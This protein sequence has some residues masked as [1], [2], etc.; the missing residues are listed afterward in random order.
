VTEIEEIKMPHDGHH[1]HDHNHAGP[2]HMHSHPINTGSGVVAHDDAVQDFIDSFIAG[3]RTADDKTGFL[4]LAKV[5][6]EIADDAGGPSLKLVDVAIED[7]YQVATASPAFA[8]EELVYHP[9]PGRMV[10]QRTDMKFVY[11]S[12]KGRRDIPLSEMAGRL[13]AV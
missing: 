9:Y 5:P 4:R 8:S 3:F 11:V 12:L 2:D 6:F 10:R 7:A 1:P 13:I